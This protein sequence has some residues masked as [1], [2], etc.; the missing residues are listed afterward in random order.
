[1]AQD[2]IRNSAYLSI[3]HVLDEL[4]FAGRVQARTAGAIHRAIDQLRLI[5][6]PAEDIVVAEAMSVAVVKLET[7]LRTSD[8]AAAEQVRVEL[9]QLGARWLQTPMRLSLN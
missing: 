8:A 9:Q 1:M 4:G 2:Q 6:A 3:Y 7:A 5:D